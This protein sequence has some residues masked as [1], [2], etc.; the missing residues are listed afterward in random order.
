MSGSKVLRILQAVKG[1]LQAVNQAGGY[2]TDIGN[3]VRLTRAQPA[4]IEAPCALVFRNDR[5]VVETSHAASRCDF[6]ITVEAYAEI[7]GDE[8]EAG[9]A[10]IADIQQAVE[11]EDETLGGL[12]TQQYGLTFQSDEIFFPE[13]GANVVGA[14]VTYSAPHIRKHGNPELG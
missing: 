13:T 1:R 14:A 11:L 5:T 6:T 4:D 2:V 3:D 12:L 7:V 8:M 10:L 9:E